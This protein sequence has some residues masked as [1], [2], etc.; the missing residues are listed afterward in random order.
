[1]GYLVVQAMA[2]ALEWPFKEEKQLQAQIA[3]GKLDNKT[4]FLLLPTTYMNESGRALRLCIDFYKLGSEQVLVV[5][6]D[7][8]LPFGEMRFR[9]QGGP[10]GHNGLKSIQTHLNTQQYARLRMGVGR[11]QQGDKTLADYVLDLFTAQELEALPPFIAQ[12]AQILRRIVTN[13]VQ[14]RE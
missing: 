3:K 5:C 12:G 1:M 9:N 10:G 11:E 8:H 14:E 4:I 13:E 6:D 2:A 7:V